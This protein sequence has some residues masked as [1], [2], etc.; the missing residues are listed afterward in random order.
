M[1]GYQITLKFCVRGKRKKLKPT[2]LVVSASQPFQIVRTKKKR[3]REVSFLFLHVLPYFGAVA[4]CPVV[5]F[6]HY[7]DSCDREAILMS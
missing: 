1:P 7:V 4:S 6:L 2:N 3:K 5:K